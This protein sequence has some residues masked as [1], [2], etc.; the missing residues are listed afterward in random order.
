[1]SFFFCD[2]ILSR[3][4][5]G[6]GGSEF[7]F[8]EI[9]DGFWLGFVFSHFLLLI[10]TNFFGSILYTLQLQ[11]MRSHSD[12]FGGVFFLSVLCA[13]KILLFSLFTCDPTTDSGPLRTPGIYSDV[14]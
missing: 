14:Y 2:S 6:P 3:S 4:K 10:S 5:F 13:L 7:I 11:P 8:H 9:V 1:M 12:D